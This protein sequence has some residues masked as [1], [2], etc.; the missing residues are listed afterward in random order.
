V[1]KRKEIMVAVQDS[2]EAK[3][4]IQETGGQDMVSVTPKKVLAKQVVCKGA[5]EKPDVNLKKDGVEK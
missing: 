2:D 1:G 5:L 3:E 4:D